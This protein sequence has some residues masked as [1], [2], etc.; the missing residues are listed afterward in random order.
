MV[1]VRP[2]VTVTGLESPQRFVQVQGGSAVFASS[3][4]VT[5]QGPQRSPQIVEVREVSSG[6]RQIEEPPE[7]T[8]TVPPLRSAASS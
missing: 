7:E 4:W 5:V 8:E 3:E 2:R 6:P 1:R